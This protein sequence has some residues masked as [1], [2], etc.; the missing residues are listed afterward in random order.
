MDEKYFTL[1]LLLFDRTKNLKKEIDLFNDSMIT[2]MHGMCVSFRV[3]NRK[4]VGGGKGRC[5]CATRER[6]GKASSSGR[7]KNDPRGN[8]SK[9][10]R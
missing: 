4:C 2:E 9:K 6:R 8:P 1:C 3:F 5:V 10:R 7:G